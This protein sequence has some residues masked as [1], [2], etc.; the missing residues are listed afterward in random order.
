MMTAGD[1]EFEPDLDSITRLPVRSPLSNLNTKI[2]AITSSIAVMT[3]GDSGIQAELISH[4]TKWVRWRLEKDKDKWVSVN[5]VVDAY[6]NIYDRVKLQHVK[7]S[8]YPKYGL[9]D[10]TFVEQ[11]H[12]LSGPML[13]KI[14]NEMCEFDAMFSSKYGI[15]TIITGIDD[16][17]GYPAPHIYVITK[18]SGNDLFA[19]CDSLGFAAIGSGSRHAESQ[20]ML[21]G[22]SRYSSSPETLLLTYLAKKRSEIAPGVGKGT[23]MFTIGP[24]LGSLCMLDNISD[25]QI[26][27]VDEIFQTLEKDQKKALKTAM[28]KTEKYIEEMFSKRAESQ[29]KQ[30]PTDQNSSDKNSESSS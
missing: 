28:K 30:S 26:G 12:Q 4:L 5:E 18:A 20:F 19:C 24:E 10:K 2:T 15:E 7:H 29:I 8:V 1:V 27:K 3:A 6:L 13:E 16:D 11:Q 21:A 14:A 25:F 23:D 9:T 22:H 17:S